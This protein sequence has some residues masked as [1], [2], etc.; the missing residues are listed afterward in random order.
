MLEG[1]AGPREGNPA[2]LSSRATSSAGARFSVSSSEASC[3][4]RAFESRSA[5]AE[6]APT[7]SS[8]PG[9]MSMTVAPA[10]PPDSAEPESDDA[11]KAR[12]GPSESVWA[13]SQVAAEETPGTPL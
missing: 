6:G 10:P 13:P 9:E 11:A 12:V 4:T 7:S 5:A 2:H 1:K 8:P 3:W